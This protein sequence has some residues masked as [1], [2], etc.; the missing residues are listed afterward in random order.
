VGIFM[1]GVDA[2]VASTVVRDTLSQES[3]GTGGRGINAQCDADLISCGSLAVTGSLVAGNREVGI[4]TA[5]V[6]GGIASTVVRDTMPEEG[7]GVF[8]RGINAECRADG[9]ACGSLTI[10]SSLVDGNENAGI[11]VSGVHVVLSGVAVRDTVPNE[12]GDWALDNGQ[13]VFAGCRYPDQGRNCPVLQMDHC[14]VE[15]SYSAGVAIQGGSGSMQGSVIR[16]VHSRR[17]DDAY[18]YGLQVEGLD[19]PGAGQTFFDVQTCL[20][21]DA[22]LAGALF[23]RSQGTV[24]GSEVGGAGFSIVMNEGASVTVS[25]DN[26]LSGTYEDDPSWQNMDP[27]PAPE[28]AMPVLD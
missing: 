18:G 23:V 17:L 9:G 7:T 24:G 22:M 12:T 2:A 26:L 16:D 28:P 27:S 1:A 25:D 21:M 11:Y 8:G 14:M 20:I 3:D 6:D 5:G 15:S 4:F 10:T 13:G 19:A